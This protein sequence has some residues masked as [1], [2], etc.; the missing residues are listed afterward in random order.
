MSL[1]VAAEESKL[2][3]S[4]RGA[5]DRRRAA[6]G[7]KAAAKSQVAARPRRVAS[8]PRADR[9]QLEALQLEELLD[10]EAG[11]GRRLAEALPTVVALAADWAGREASWGR[12]A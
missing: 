12:A 5:V 2:V 7:L 10:L 1:R 9:P 4:Q 6:D 3:A 11:A 8:A